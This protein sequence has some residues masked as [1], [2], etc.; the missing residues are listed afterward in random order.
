MALPETIEQDQVMENLDWAAIR[1]AATGGLVVLVPAAILTEIFV[2]GSSG[3]ALAFLFF[4]ITMFGF[5]T[6]GF[7]A[8]RLRSD[9]PMVH[10]MIAALAAWAVIQAFGVIKLLIAG[11]DITWLAL[12]LTALIAS[13]AGVAGAVFAD[14]SRRKLPTG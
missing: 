5:A 9:R 7:G 4:A 8:G 3:G 11:D 1:H 13:S 12:P 6:A 14:W 2:D 10:G